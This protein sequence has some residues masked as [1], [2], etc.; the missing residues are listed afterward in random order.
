MLKRIFCSISAF[1]ISLILIGLMFLLPFITIFHYLPIPSFYAE[2]TAAALGLAAALPL[3]RTASWQTIEIPQISL[4]F[5]GLAAILGMQWMLGILHSIQYALLTLS[6]LTWGFLLVVLGGHL[7]HKLGWE[8]LVTTLAWCLLSAGVI[9]ACI[10]VLQFV[11]RTGG[12]IPLLPN[13]SSY[14][15]LSQPNHFASFA[16]LATASLVYLYAKGRLSLSFFSLILACFL[17]MLSFSGSRSSWFYLIALTTLAIVTQVNARKQ[18]TACTATRSL[19]RASLWLIPAFALAQLFIYYFIPNDLVNLPTERLVDAANA[20]S[21]SARLHIWYDSLRLFS[22]SPWLG[23]GAGNMRAETFLL[24]DKPSPMAFKLVFEHAHNLFLHLLAEMGIGAF[25]IVLVGLISWLRAF[26]WRALDLETWWLITLLAVLGIHSMLEY[27]LWF[28]YFL[29][30]TAV[31]LGAGDE[32]TV[33]VSPTEVVRNFAQSGLIVILLL[34]AVN[35][36]TMMIANIKLE[37]WV[38]QWANNSV[39]SQEK[40]LDWIS[41]YSVLSPYYE[42]MSALSMTVNLTD[43]DKK[44]SLSQSVMRFKPLRR[45]AYQHALLLQLQGDHVNAA[46]QLNRALIAYPSKPEDILNAVPLEYR[47]AYLDLLYEVRPTLR[48]KIDINQ[49]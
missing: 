33:S 14:G 39:T 21:A 24:L 40:E 27:P 34:G 8:K 32:K 18:Q 26:K 35:L 10:V 11:T 38:Q 3:L 15:A 20:N 16:V 37:N 12:V 4:V 13:L 7:R 28:A 1:N 19:L 42:L 29:G 17:M 41:K 30:I 9:N 44:V 48:N 49:Y 43:I 45:V 2:W 22:Q 31:L 46:K 36:G 25:L 23:V 47:P 6:Y 5:L